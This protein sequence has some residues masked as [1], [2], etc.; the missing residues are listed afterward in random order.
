MFALKEISQVEQHTSLKFE[1]ENSLISMK[2][3][4]LNLLIA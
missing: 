1:A 3:K 2:G 4:V